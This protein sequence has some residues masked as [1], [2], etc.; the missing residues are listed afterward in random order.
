M[1]VKYDGSLIFGV[2]IERICLGVGV[3]VAVDVEDCVV[4]AVFRFIDEFLKRI[5]VIFADLE[6]SRPFVVRFF[7]LYLFQHTRWLRLDIKSLLV[8]IVHRLIHF[9]R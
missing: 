3:T 8:T 7:V 4:V 1:L 5:L 9:I 2:I 6:Q